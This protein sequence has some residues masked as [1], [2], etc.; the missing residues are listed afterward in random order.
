MTEQ[1]S[2]KDIVRHAC[3]HMELLWVELDSGRL[4][5]TAAMSEFN[6]AKHYVELMAKRLHV[7]REIKL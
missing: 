6:L 4:E 3:D 2:T 7:E 5:G 1:M